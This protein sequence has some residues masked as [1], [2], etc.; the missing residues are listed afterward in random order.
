ME[1]AKKEIKKLLK[2]AASEIQDMDWT[3]IG[4]LGWY[5]VNEAL[6]Q[7]KGMSASCNI[8]NA[9]DPERLEFQ[10]LAVRHKTK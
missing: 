2:D 3:D 7:D 5:L 1:K 6:K 10:G 8:Y 4:D 9:K